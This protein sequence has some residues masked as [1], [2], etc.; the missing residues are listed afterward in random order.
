MTIID[1]KTKKMADVINNIMPF[2]NNLYFRTG[3]FFFSGYKEIYKNLKNKNVKILVG[4]DIQKGLGGI[5]NEL[6]YQNLAHK[7]KSK[8]RSEYYDSLVSTFSDVNDVDNKDTAEAWEIFKAKI[9]D[10]TLQIRKS[11]EPDHSKVYVFENSKEHNQNGEYMGVVIKGSSNLTYSGLK[12]QNEDNDLY[13]E[14]EKFIFYKQRFE[15]LWETSIPLVDQE[16]LVAFENEV[17]KKVW[18]DQLPMPYYVFLRVIDEYFTLVQN[19]DILTPAQITKNKINLRYQVDAVRQA[20]SII[21]KHNGVIIADVVGLGKSIIGSTVAKNLNIKTIVI[22]PPHL[23]QQWEDYR[24]EFGFNAKVYGTG[25]VLKAITE[26]NEDEQKLI[27]V[28]EAHK[29][30]NEEKSLYANLHRLCKGNKVILLS[31]TP[32]NN[33]PK[34]I[35]ALIKLFQVP[36][37]STIQTIDNLS[38]RFKDLIKKYN[39]LK[40]LKGTGVPDKEVKA[41]INKFAEKIKDLLGPLLIRRSRIDLQNINIYRED[42]KLQGI[43]FPEIEKP[44][45]IK[46]EFGEYKKLYIDTLLQIVPGDQA[47]GFKG[48]RYNVIGYINDLE[49]IEK[50]A[51]N[52]NIDPKLIQKVQKNLASFMKRLLV[53]RFES[54]IMAFKKTLNKMILSYE[55]I[56]KWYEKGFVPIY[57]KGDLPDLEEFENDDGDEVIEKINEIYEIYEEKGMELIKADDLSDEYIKD[58]NSDIKL[59]KEIKIQWEIFE[60]K[61]DPK[62]E[63]VKKQ[64]RDSFEKNPARKIIVFSMYSDTIDYLYEQIKD[65]FKVFKYSSETSTTANKEIIKKNFDAG[66]NN[67]VNDFELLL[68]TDV[69]SEGYNLNR[70]GIIINYDIPYNPTRVI[71][72]VGRI[73]RINKKIFPKLYIYNFFPSPTGEV[74]TGVRR[75]STLKIDVIKALLGDDTKYLSEDEILKS[76]DEKLKEEMNQ[77]EEESWDSKYRNIIT[78]LQ[79]TQHIEKAHL[80]P[81]RTKI[82]RENTIQKGVLVFGRKGGDYAFKLGISDKETLPLTA[83]EAIKLFEAKAE[84]QPS[85]ISD[86]FYKIYEYTKNNLFIRKS[87]VPKD[88]GLIQ[89]IEKINQLKIE[90]PEFKDY[91]EDLE[92][93]M[94]DLGDLPLKF[95]RTIRAIRKEQIDQDV[96]NLMIEIPHSYL[97]KIIN[98]ADLVEEGQE[99]LILAEELR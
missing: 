37:K 25:S 87:E 12:G 64:I 73:N 82:K 45:N 20:L 65:D 83:A 49:K 34:D 40:K 62:I 23:I 86:D 60:P 15:E 97:I 29:F 52:L 79:N 17:I 35:F 11:L 94:K 63:E 57:K 68:A 72:R 44:I 59:L 36:A 2:A 19:E 48:A 98:E 90:K 96:K 91:F 71:Q 6:N 75:I 5:I 56:K 88:K 33:N 18:P 47:K 28:D 30:R 81:I 95:A 67:Q 78:S 76:Y 24:Y 58:L 38:L 8:V 3:Y 9:K 27:I 42:L 66:Y 89:A 99:S 43:E 22:T 39:K 74:E 61:K 10:G 69:I 41:E 50:I 13:K 31:A 93:V 80:I 85:K 46:Y 16:N 70:A 77:T 51:K 32:F 53:H 1:N 21:K 7:P 55:T 92:Y 26:N 4:K 54:S 14:N 84:E